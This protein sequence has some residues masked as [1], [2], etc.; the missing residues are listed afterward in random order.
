MA[1]LVTGGAGFIG[2]HTCLELLGHGYEVVVVDDFSNSSPGALT[3]VRQLAGRDLILH[4]LD[5]RDHRALCQVFTRH[6]IDAVIHFAAKKAIGESL[7]MPLEYFDVNIAGTTSLLR[8]MARHRVR[9]LVFSSSCSIYG[10]EYSEPIGENAAPAPTNPYARSKLACEQILADVCA[11]VSEFTVI[12]LRYFN[13]VGAHPGGALGEVP[14]GVPNNVMPYMMRVAAGLLDRLQVFGVDYPTA[15]GSAVRDYIHVMDVA[16]AHRLAVE[17]LDDGPGMH[18]LNLGTGAGVSVLEL[19]RTFE[20]TCG[21]TVPVEVAGRREGD[22]PAAVADPGRA[23][24]EWGWRTS[25]DIRAM[26]RDAWRFQQGHPAGYGG[27]ASRARSP[28][29]AGAGS[30]PGRIRNARYRHRHRLSWRRPRGLHGQDR[31]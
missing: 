13:P 3:V 1:V 27:L 18:V 14:R 4:E 2:S 12:S 25:R 23:E 16:E 30:L 15:D 19:V 28:P 20:E 21:V 5:V 11:A 6:R 8:C 29:P 17:R 31:P 10:G 7:R 22:A 26:C 24:K 9:R